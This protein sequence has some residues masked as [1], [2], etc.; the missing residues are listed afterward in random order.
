[1]IKLG[2]I[3][4]TCLFALNSCGTSSSEHLK[5]VPKK[6][7]FDTEIEN[8]VNTINYTDI[9]DISNSHNDSLISLKTIQLIE[10]LFQS[11]KDSVSNTLNTFF[12]GIKQ[13]DKALAIADSVTYLY[14]NDPNSPVRNDELYIKVLES[15]LATNPSNEAIKVRAEETLRLLNLNRP[16]MKASNFQF[17]TRSGKTRTI[18]ELAHKMTL[19]IFY[20]PE[21]SHCSDI[22][23]S[24]A[25]NALINSKIKDG[26]LEVLAIYAEG[27]IEIW[28][29]TKDRMPNNWEI[30]YDLT[31]IL[32]ND[33]Y[34]LPA[35]P[36]LFLLNHEKK[37]ILKDPS[38]NILFSF[39]S[40]K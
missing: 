13:N 3:L 7:H 4:S 18:E 32:D 39:F 16:G 5:D 14:L 35:M 10:L 24:L 17:I 33:L 12:N 38:L 9:S 34:D 36:T 28:E 40:T 2:L 1:M 23:K 19:L 8:Y 6:S 31:G 26:T 30:G 22:L 25:N 37:V 21:C 11:D 15:I 20:D 29:D 27:N